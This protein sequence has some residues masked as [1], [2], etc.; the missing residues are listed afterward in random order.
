MATESGKNIIDAVTLATT[1]G[2]IFLV[3]ENLMRAKVDAIAFTN[4]GTVNSKITVHVVSKDGAVADTNILIDEK[5]IRVGE[6]YLAPELIGQGIEVG[7]NIQA[8][9]DNPTSVSCTAT[10]TLYS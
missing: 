10:G 2:S 4:F 7:G 5:E 6:T 1:V 8:F 9:A 3:T